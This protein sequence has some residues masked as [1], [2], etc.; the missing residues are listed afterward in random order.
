[1]KQILKSMFVLS[2]MFIVF[3]LAAVWSMA[4]FLGG[5]QLHQEEIARLA[6]SSGQIEA[7][8]IEADAG[9]TAANSYWVHVLTRGEKKMGQPAVVL[10]GVL[11]N[12][13][14]YGVHLDWAAPDILRIKYSTVQ[15]AMTI[16][17]LPFSWNNTAF[18]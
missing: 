15:K 6:S 5:S 11:C 12:D 16:T 14:E 7:V 10:S 9:A 8:M 3:G 18:I 17:S 1:M 13:K 2:A 4:W